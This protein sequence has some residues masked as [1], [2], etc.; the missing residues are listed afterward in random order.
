MIFEDFVS[1]LFL[2]LPTGY[3]HRNVRD[4]VFLY[5]LEKEKKLG[6]DFLSFFYRTGNVRLFEFCKSLKLSLQLPHHS[7]IFQH[8]YS[9]IEP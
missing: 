8:V 9:S 1:F 6:G 4:F 5:E 7:S 2:F 3:S